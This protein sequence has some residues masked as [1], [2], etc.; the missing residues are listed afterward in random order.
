M[1]PKFISVIG[2]LNTDLVTT[3]ARLPLG[4]ETLTATSF[5]TGLGG[6]G[7]NQAV[8]CARLSQPNPSTGLQPKIFKNVNVKM[9]GAVG[10]D[11]FGPR[12]KSSMA[13]DGVDISSVEVKNGQTTGVAVII[14]EESTGENR[15]LLNPGANNT[16]MPDQFEQVSSLGIPLPDI[17]I[18][19]L[20]I[21]LA[22]V[23]QIIKI[24]KN[25]GV[26][27]ILNPAPAAIL[28]AEAYKNLSHLIL[29]ESEASILTGRSLSEVSHV[30]FDWKVVIMEFLA[31]G[32]QNVII[33]LGARGAFFASNTTDEVSVKHMP[34]FKVNK[35]V[36]T[37]AAGDT[38]VGAYAL[39]IVRGEKN[40]EEVIRYACL[41]AARTIEKRGAQNSIPWSDEIDR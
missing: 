2:S 15:I 3:T 28:P 19:Q 26:E 11:E 37:T 39:G 4:G 29:N 9:I 17:I 1:K 32:V 7:A 5:F 12:M 27:V 33:T 13:L 38:F 30:D 23:L 41:T 14:V 21:P 25:A 40:K 18:L 24:A 20:E 36:D 34:A 8:A 22:T 35:V 31:K 10:A 6:K 16:L